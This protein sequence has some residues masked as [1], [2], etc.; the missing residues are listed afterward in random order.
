MC[1][2]DADEIASEVMYRLLRARIRAAPSQSL[3]LSWVNTATR[4][5]LRE[6]WRAL[7]RTRPLGGRVLSALASD[8]SCPF[9]SIEEA[10]HVLSRLPSPHQQVLILRVRGASRRDV[11][12]YLALWRP[13][14]AGRAKRLIREA[15]SMARALR[16]GEDLVA[17]YPGRYSRGNPWLATPPPPLAP[18]S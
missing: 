3:L 15:H 5:V 11:S 8:Q 18:L 12:E 1:S 4:N 2:A 7:S 14:G 13:G 9:D 16:E 10:I 6:H 17:C